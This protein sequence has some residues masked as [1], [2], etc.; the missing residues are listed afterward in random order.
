VDVPEIAVDE[1]A[2][3]H[4]DDLTIIDVR[5]PDEYEQVHA[6]GAYLIPL[7]QIADRVTE[8][9]TDGTVYIICATG[10]RS[11]R[12]AAFLREQGI[13]AVNVAGGTKAWAEAGYP[14]ATGGA[15]S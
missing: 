14:V 8:I 1:L 7:P 3:Q 13:D 10:G 9:P 11:A 12:A 5:M 4:D 6:D 2:R 15:P